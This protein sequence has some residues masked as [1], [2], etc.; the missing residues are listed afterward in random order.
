MEDA[1]GQE[2]E[3]TVAILGVMDRPIRGEVNGDEDEPIKAVGLDEMALKDW[4]PGCCRDGDGAPVTLTVLGIALDTTVYFAAH[5]QFTRNVLGRQ[6][7]LNLV[8]LGVVDY[9]GKLY[10]SHYND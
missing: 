5:E 10:L 1:S 2:P 7:W 3:G 4:T 9:E 6:G 8:R